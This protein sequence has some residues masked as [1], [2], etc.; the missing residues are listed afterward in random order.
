M[1]ALIHYCQ[2]R[3]LDQTEVMN[4]LQDRGLISDNAVLMEEVAPKDCAR[5]VEWLR[6]RAIRMLHSGNSGE[7]TVIQ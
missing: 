2:D 6:I 1:N 7:T 3:N 4:A 5:A